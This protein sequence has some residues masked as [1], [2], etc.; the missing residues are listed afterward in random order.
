MKFPQIYGKRLWA[1]VHWPKRIINNYVD[2]SR[3][4]SV[5]GVVVGGVVVVAAAAANGCLSLFGLCVE[6]NSLGK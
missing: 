3:L 1:K 5:A 6:S 4:Y 2:G